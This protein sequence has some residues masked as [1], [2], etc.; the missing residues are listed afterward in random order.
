M[1]EFRQGVS[2][3]APAAR[4]NICESSLDSATP[5]IL[6]LRKLQGNETPQR[7]GE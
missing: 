6:Q 1:D 7:E 5:V 3:N 2:Q 4:I